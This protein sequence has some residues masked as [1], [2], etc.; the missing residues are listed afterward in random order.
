MSYCTSQPVST[1][2]SAEVSLLRG[3][4]N[5]LQ[6]SAV[7]SMNFL[8]IVIYTAPVQVIIPSGK[9]ELNSML[10]C[11]TRRL[12]GSGSQFLSR[13]HLRCFVSDISRDHFP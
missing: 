2:R 7:K 9:K 12:S 10:M 5:Q 6:G 4:R 1:C 13:D 11:W 3:Q 8:R